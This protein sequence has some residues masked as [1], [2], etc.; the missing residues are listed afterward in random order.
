LD[1]AEAGDRSDAGGLM[2]ED[3]ERT[4]EDSRDD[5]EAPSSSLGLDHG[6]LEPLGTRGSGEEGPLKAAGDAG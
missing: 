1:K 6:L 2:D 4:D 5:T 3:I